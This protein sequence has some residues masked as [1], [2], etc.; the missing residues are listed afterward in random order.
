MNA[1][2][3]TQLFLDSEELK[4]LRRAARSAIRGRFN[5]RGGILE[6]FADQALVTLAE[7]AHGIEN[8]RGKHGFMPHV[9]RKTECVVCGLRKD[10]HRA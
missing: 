2:T 9:A 8:A 3:I 10:E 1:T 4:Q 7:K 5:V 6:D